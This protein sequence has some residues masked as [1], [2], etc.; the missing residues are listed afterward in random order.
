MKTSSRSPETHIAN[1]F[2]LVIHVSLQNKTHPPS[3]HASI[4]HPRLI[5][6]S[7]SSSPRQGNFTLPRLMA[8]SPVVRM[9]TLNAWL[10][11]LGARWETVCCV[12]KATSIL[13]QSIR[14]R[15][16][17]LVVLG[18]PGERVFLTV[19]GSRSVLY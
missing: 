3:Q 7:S 15:N 13:G 1:L 18:N 14:W 16:R 19:Q 17:V 2:E 9:E 6:N 12:A 8:A 4:H 5:Y 11:L 10:C